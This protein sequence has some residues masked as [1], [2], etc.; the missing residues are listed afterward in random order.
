MSYNDIIVYVDGTE[1]AKARVAF[2]VALAKEQDAHLIG[3]AFAPRAL[4]PLYGADV[5]FADM[6][7]VLQ[8]V[9]AQ[10]EAALERFRRAPPPRASAP[11][12]GSCKA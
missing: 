7:G 1:A 6:S 5:G 2:A 11:R 4:L 12:D 10:G 9:K 3:L 8:D